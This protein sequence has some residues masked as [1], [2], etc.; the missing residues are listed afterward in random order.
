M[1]YCRDGRSLQSQSVILCLHPCSQA[2][3]LL[4]RYVCRAPCRAGYDAP[5]AMNKRKFADGGGN[6]WVHMRFRSGTPLL[7]TSCMGQFFRPKTQH[8]THCRITGVACRWAVSSDHYK[9]S[10]K[11][12]GGHFWDGERT[13]QDG[14]NYWRA[15]GSCC[16][17]PPGRFAMT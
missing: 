4:T 10:G 1:R 6:R 12:T 9:D 3:W 2:V 15:A 8:F 7:R 16:P 5:T 17:N 11:H 13:G 14:S